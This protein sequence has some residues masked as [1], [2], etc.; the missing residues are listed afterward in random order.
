MCTAICPP[1]LA[2]RCII[3]GFPRMFPPIMK[4]VAEVEALL[5]SR[6]SYSF[7]D[8][9]PTP[10]SNVSCIVSIGH[11]RKQGILTAQTPSGGM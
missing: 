1:E 8:A 5:A 2:H 9:G 6:K 4:W 10:S 7:A 11:K 3:V